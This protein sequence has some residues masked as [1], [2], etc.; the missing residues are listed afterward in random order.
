MTGAEWKP[1]RVWDASIR[2]FHWFLVAVLAASLLSERAGVEWIHVAADQVMAV[3]LSFRLVWGFVGSDTARLSGFVR[4][5]RAAFDFARTWAEPGGRD[6]TVGHNPLGGWMVVALLLG[7]SSLVLTG[8]FARGGGGTIAGP[9][10]TLVPSEIA[11]LLTPLHRGISSLTALLVAVHVAA[12]V[13]YLV[14]KGDDLITPMITG[15]KSLPAGTPAPR[16]MGPGRA[17]PVL[18]IVSAALGAVVFA[19]RRGG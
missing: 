11:E 7:L 16:L 14:F 9:L 10:A 17:V 6:T 15:N 1:V 12:I 5:P 18:L 4:G 8:M 19:V 13:A 3:L 2:L